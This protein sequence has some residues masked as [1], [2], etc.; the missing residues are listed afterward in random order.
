MREGEEGSRAAKEEKDD[1]QE[2]EED[3]EEV[4]MCRWQRK[5]RRSYEPM[6]P[7][8]RTLHLHPCNRKVTYDEC[9]MYEKTVESSKLWTCPKW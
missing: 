5:F 1:E 2:K 9:S 7:P 8:R 4:S 6:P 3:K